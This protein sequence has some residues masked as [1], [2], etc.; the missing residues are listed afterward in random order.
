MCTGSCPQIDSGLVNGTSH[1]IQRELCHVGLYTIHLQNEFYIPNT[2][3]MLRR[4]QSWI[5]HRYDSWISFSPIVCH[6]P[7]VNLS[8]GWGKQS[9]I[10]ISLLLKAIKIRKTAENIRMACSKKRERDRRWKKK[11]VSALIQIVYS[12]R[13][14]TFLPWLHCHVTVKLWGMSIWAILN[15]LI[16]IGLN[17]YSQTASS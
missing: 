4:I 17:S 7:L 14:R 5:K 10:Y 9:Y 3:Y 6:L 15:V 8:E 1:M 16:S 13:S 12:F 2:I 11:K